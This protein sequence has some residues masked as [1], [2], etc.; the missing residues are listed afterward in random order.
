MVLIVQFQKITIPS[1]WKVIGNYEGVEGLKCQ[2]SWRS[3]KCEAKLKFVVVV[4]T[5]TKNLL[6]GEWIFFWN[7]A[8]G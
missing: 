6:C 8:F 7:N 5:K 3:G 4:L 1:P 2:N